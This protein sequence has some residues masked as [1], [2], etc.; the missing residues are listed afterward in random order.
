[1]RQ[2]VRANKS[3]C[4]GCGACVSICPKHA[5]TMQPDEEGFLYPAVNSELCVECDLCEKRC[6]VGKEIPAHK[7][8]AYGMQHKDETIRRQSS[9]GGVF[10]ALARGMFASGGVVFGAAFDETLRVEHIGAFDETELAAMR[11]SK[12][13]QSDAAEAIGNATALLARGIPVLFSG[14]PCQVDGLLAKVKAKDRERLLTVDFVCHG[15]PSPGVFASYIAQIEKKHGQKVCAYTFR[16]KRLGWKDFSAVATLEDGTQISGTQRDEPYL[17]GFLQNL[18]LRP[19]CGQCVNLRGKRHKSD[20]TI[21]DF[22][23][24]QEICPERDDDTGLSLVMVNTQKGREA[25]RAAEKQLIVFAADTEKMMRHNPSIEVPAVM[26]KKREAFFKFYKKN[27]FDSERV[28]KMLAGPSRAQQIILRI[29][30]LPVG[31]A[32]RVCRLLGIKGRKK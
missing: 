4:T 32:R 13:V 25:L 5:I 9:S 30:H 7:L 26:H 20:I 29:L 14:T 17:Y 6:P 19:S 31:A 22:W 27:G 12:Y 16:D 1:M 18:Y 15:V 28:M 11:G 23:G 21:A 24:S 3:E 2:T 10:T 8:H